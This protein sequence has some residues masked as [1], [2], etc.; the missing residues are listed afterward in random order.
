MFEMTPE[1][2]ANAMP[3]D[4]ANKVRA[5]ITNLDKKTIGFSIPPGRSLSSMMS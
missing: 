4:W 3:T 1:G 5:A 2:G